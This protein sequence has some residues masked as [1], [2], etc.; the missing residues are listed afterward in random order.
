MT[1]EKDPAQVTQKEVMLVRRIVMMLT[2]THSPW[3]EVFVVI[4]A[5]PLHE[6]RGKNA[7]HLQNGFSQEH[8][9]AW[10]KHAIGFN[11]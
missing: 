9:S 7:A 5:A 4:V 3:L 10:K 11:R 2:L 1:P 8:H 6:W